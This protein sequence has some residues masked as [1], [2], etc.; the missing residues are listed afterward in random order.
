[1]PPA[2]EHALTSCPPSLPA[3]HPA[4]NP[5]P[6]R[7]NNPA[8][9]LEWNPAPPSHSKIT[10]D[11]PTRSGSRSDS[12]ARNVEETLDKSDLHAEVVQEQQRR[13]DQY[14]HRHAQFHPPL[15]VATVV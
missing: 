11:P 6:T 10:T 7:P 2:G 9:P 5:R 14:R 8:A 15:S 1:M 12:A 4:D 13:G 3:P